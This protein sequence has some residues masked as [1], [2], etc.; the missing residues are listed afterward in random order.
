MV[1]IVVVS[2][3]A[4]LAAGVADLARQMSQQG[5]RLAVAAGVDD[6]EQPIGTNAIKVMDAI[7]EVFDPSGVVVMMD[8]GSAILSAETALELLPADLANNVKLCAAPFVEGTV[9]ATVAAA[10]G[11][12]LEQVIAEANGALAAKQ[13]QLHQPPISQEYGAWPAESTRSERVH[14]DDDTLA[15][16]THL[17]WLVR[18]PQ[19]LHARPA[20]QLV[21]VLAQLDAELVLEKNGQQANPRSINQIA[22]L[23]IRNGDR[24]RFSARGP[25]ADVAISAFKH[26]M[27]SNFGETIAPQP[28]I[29]TPPAKPKVISHADRIQG[30]PVS[31]GVTWGPVLQFHRRQVDGHPAPA[32]SPQAELQRLEAGFRR[33]RA[34]L[35]Q[36]AIQLSAELSPAVAAIFEAQLVLLS[37]PELYEAVKNRI[38]SRQQSAEAAWQAEID[39]LA[40]GYRALD[41]EY[42][43]AREL[44]IHDIGNRVN[45]QLADRPLQQIAVTKPVILLADELTPS[46]TATLDRERVLGICLSGG[47]HLSHSSIIAKAMGIPTVVQ[48]RDCLRRTQRD[49]L[50]YLDA[51]AGILWLSPDQATRRALEKQ[52]TG[53]HQAGHAIAP[54]KDELSYE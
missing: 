21:S 43:Q 10:S 35:Q 13:T 34:A 27:T 7:K 54:G 11:L 23:Q 50:V 3:S 47:S 29:D 30:I 41:D 40:A 24:I 48:A 45:D 12:P 42:M 18:N 25:D 26:L 4:K 8:M 46:A 44:D 38:C 31:E 17:E 49:Q 53:R 52:G 51:T 1:S 14:D 6:P 22:A 39:N 16:M 28:P 15:T 2:H 32:G 9:A 37:D 36:L 33:A 20:A 19:G 5:C